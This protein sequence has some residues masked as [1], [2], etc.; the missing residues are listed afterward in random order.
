LRFK[1]VKFKSFVKIRIILG[2]WTDCPILFCNMKKLKKIRDDR[3]T[4]N[5]ISF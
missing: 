1:F 4:F 5:F 3:A 2:F